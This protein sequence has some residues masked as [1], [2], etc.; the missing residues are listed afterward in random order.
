MTQKFQWKS[1]ST[2]WVH[3]LPSNPSILNLSPKLFPC[4]TKEKNMARKVNKRFFFLWKPIF[5]IYKKRPQSAQLMVNGYLGQFVRFF[6]TVTRKWLNSFP[7]YFLA[8]FW[9]AN[10]PYQSPN[11]CDGHFKKLNEIG[12][13]N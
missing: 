8:K 12:L 11:H 2:T 13:S 5:S 9:G 3:L 4:P 1:C 6:F 7:R 10:Q